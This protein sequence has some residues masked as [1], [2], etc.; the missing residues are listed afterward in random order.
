[1][2]ST[3]PGD[4]VVLGQSQVETA[5]EPAVLAGAVLAAI[6]PRAVS[7]PLDPILRKAGLMTTL[8]LL[9]TGD[10]PTGILQEH[11]TSLL[12]NAPARPDIDQL[13]LAFA[14]AQVPLTPWAYSIDSTGESILDLIEADPL[15][16]QSA[17]EVLTDGDWISLQ[18][19]CRS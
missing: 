14:T 13:V 8:R 7:D 12:Q 10:I 16:D 15:K 11:A 2:S 1:M 9:T 18:G 5:S 6:A 19:I 3:C 4:I 17:P